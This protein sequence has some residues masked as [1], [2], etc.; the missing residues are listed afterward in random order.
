ML[1][2][3]N[4]NLKDYDFFYVNGCS[5]TE[6]GGLEE[7]KLKN[8][9]CLPIYKEKHNVSWDSRKDVNYAQRLTEITGIPHVNHGR[10][11]AGTDRVVRTTY[12]FIYENWDRK[13][14]FF[15]I[16]EN[17]DPS[18]SDV[19][20][21][22]TGEHYIVNAHY[23]KK[24]EKYHL[25]EY[26]IDYYNQKQDD[27]LWDT[28][29]NWFDNHYDFEQKLAQDD[30]SFIG[31]YSFCKMNGIQIYVMS[32]PNFFFDDCILPEDIISFNEPNYN[33]FDYSIN[34]WCKEKKLTITDEL[35]GDV[36]DSHPGYFGHIEYSNQLAKFLGWT[37]NLIS[38]KKII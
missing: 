30:K 34:C 1:T 14:K 22:K 25:G 6:G 4:M 17:P 21:K 37:G 36:F 33:G 2:T 28:F 32:K 23:D 24:V 16:L 12:D 8:N 5:Y 38:N 20:L 35:N 3:C 29:S 10:C 9:S 31:L 11:G 27:S 13:D 19:Y 26:A 7:P 15:I 18:R